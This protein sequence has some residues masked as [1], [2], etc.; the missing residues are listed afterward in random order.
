MNT[1]LWVLQG[2]LALWFAMPAFIKLSSTEAQL[3][4]K[5]MLEAGG[6]A[7]P[8]RILGALEGLGVLGIILPWWL[9]ILPVLTPVTA[10]CFALVMAG[11]TAVHL[12]KKEYKIVPAVVIAGIISIIVAY[13]RFKGLGA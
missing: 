10:V 7:L 2:L 1:T 5:G 3:Q 4:E 6:N 11:A 12:S 13:F 9:G 8:V